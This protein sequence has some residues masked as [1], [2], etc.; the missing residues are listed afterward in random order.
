[1]HERTL[2]NEIEMKS[3]RTRRKE[4]FSMGEATLAEKVVCLVAV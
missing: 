1:M 4:M 3:R 2:G